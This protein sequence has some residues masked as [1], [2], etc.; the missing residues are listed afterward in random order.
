MLLA[1]TAEFKISI[2]SL[3]DSD[4]CCFGG[5]FDG[6]GDGEGAGDTVFGCNVVS[7]HPVFDAHGDGQGEAFGVGPVLFWSFIC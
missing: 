7:E 5:M 1:E 6:N 2:A 3:R 4:I